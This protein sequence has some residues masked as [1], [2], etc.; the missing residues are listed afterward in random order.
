VGGWE[1][2]GEGEWVSLREGER[3]TGWVG[4]SACDW[5]E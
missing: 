1:R 5:D 4:E 2:G 3:V